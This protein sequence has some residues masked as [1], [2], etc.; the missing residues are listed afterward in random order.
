M[1]RFGGTISDLGENGLGTALEPWRPTGVG[2]V[3]GDKDQE[4][5]LAV[6]GFG[7]FAFGFSPI[8]EF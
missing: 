6:E 8:S 4:D 2:G 7:G 3:G 1:N 5:Q